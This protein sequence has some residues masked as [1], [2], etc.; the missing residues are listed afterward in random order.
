MLTTDRIGRP[1]KTVLLFVLVLVVLES[2]YLFTSD[3]SPIVSV[4]KTTASLT[5]LILT[6]LGE[7]V[8]VDGVF[9]YSPLLNLRI[10]SECTAITPTMVFAAA[11]LVF[12][13]SPYVKLK[14]ILL[15]IVALYLVNLV[16][17]VSLYYIGTRAP[18]LMEFA[19]IVV[20]QAL[21]VLLAV[22]MWYLWATKYS[23]LRRT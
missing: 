11:V 21:M 7:A 12:P 8:R 1:G 18:D 20:W 17:V 22:G 6:A 19:H 2:V 16:R 5:A 14:G 4:A 9:I 13:S 10:V 3:T 15:G 23:E